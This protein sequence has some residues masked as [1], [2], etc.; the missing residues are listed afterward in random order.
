MVTLKSGV[1]ATEE[2]TAFSPA[3]YCGRQVAAWGAQVLAVERPE[4][5]PLRRQPPTATA[6]G[7]EQ[8]SALWLFIGEGKRAFTVDVHTAQGRETLNRFLADADAFVTDWS[9]ARLQQ[10]G[11][12]RESLA[13]RLP[14]LV[15][16]AVSPFGGDGPYAGYQGTDLIVQALSG[17]MGVTGLPDREPLTTLANIIPYA[18]GVSAFIGALAALWERRSGGRGQHVEVSCL[19]ATASL[20]PFLRTQYSGRPTPRQ[21]GSYS[22]TRLYPCRD[23]FIALSAHTERGWQSL[24]I[25]FGLEE[26]DVP[27]PLRTV[28]PLTLPG[29]AARMSPAPAA[30]ETRTPARDPGA[31]PA[32]AAPPLAGVRVVDLTQ[33]W[34]GPYAT[35][36][37][38]DLGADV[39]KIESHKRPDVWRDDG[40]GR[41]LGCAARLS[42][43]V[44]AD[45]GRDG[46]GPAL[47]PAHG[48]A[49]ARRPPP[50]RAHRRG[51][52][53][54]GLDVRGRRRLRR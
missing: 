13:A 28:G 36:L 33:A 21:G 54:R 48:R 16:V 17:F 35:M 39:V 2:V 7:G 18:C 34:I 24:L 41:R 30:L 12:D 22:G 3:A 26:A 47:R 27:E 44:A 40:G 6:A 51:R 46:G 1:S 43:R 19:E 50:P 5:S 10:A 53:H 29:Q 49:R 25:A 4:G 14:R 8:L 20:V 23:G 11:R 15:V 45:A 52:A 32:S 9:P 31:A 42:G 38:A 37:L